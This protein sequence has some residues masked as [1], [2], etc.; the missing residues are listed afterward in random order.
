MNDLKERGLWTEAIR[1]RIKLSDGSVQYVDDIPDDLKRLYQTAWEL[2]QKALIDMAAARGPYI[3]QSQSLNLFMAAPTIGKLD[4]KELQLE[5]VIAQCGISRGRM[6]G[7]INFG[8]ALPEEIARFAS[9]FSVPDVVLTDTSDDARQN[10]VS[11][12]QVL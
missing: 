7:I 11:A 9:F 4:H 8:Q 1:N 6:I 2:P 10:Y 3:D 5:D 12:H